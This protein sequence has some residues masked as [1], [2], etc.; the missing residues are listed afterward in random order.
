M[1]SIGWGLSKLNC[2][3]GAEKAAYILVGERSL[4]GQSFRWHQLLCC[5]ADLHAITAM[6]M[7]KE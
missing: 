7:R 5:Y 6:G 4:G 1:L 2:G 3:G